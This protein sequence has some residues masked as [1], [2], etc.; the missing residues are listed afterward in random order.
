MQ[1][2]LM[3]CSTAGRV[4]VLDPAR[5]SDITNRAYADIDGQWTYDNQLDVAMLIVCPLAISVSVSTIDGIRL[6]DR[7]QHVVISRQASK[8]NMHC[9]VM[10]KIIHALLCNDKQ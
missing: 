4:V 6:A 1:F 8:G 7:V 3:V 5:K 10:S 2:G 9:P